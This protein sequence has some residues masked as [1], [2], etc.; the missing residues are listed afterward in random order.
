MQPLINLTPYHL[1]IL[2]N[3]SKSE[4]PIPSKILDKNTSYAEKISRGSNRLTI[5]KV[6]HDLRLKYIP[7]IK[8]SK[9]Y[10]YARDEKEINNFVKKL[11]ENIKYFEQELYAVKISKKL[12][13]GWYDPNKF[14]MYVN[15]PIRSGPDSVKIERFECDE[16]GNPNI[17]VGINVIK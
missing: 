6:V 9:G 15:L 5:K 10:F 12:I 14:C 7:I 17:P 4:Y 13:K 11:E 1:R 8:N 2:E 16:E 3:L